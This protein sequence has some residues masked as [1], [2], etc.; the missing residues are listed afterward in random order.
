M[1]VTRRFFL[2]GALSLTATSALTA[3]YAFGL[4]PFRLRVQRYTLP[5]NGWSGRPLSIAALS[6][7]HACRPWMGPARIEAIVETT[8]ALA[9]D[10]IVLLGDYTAGHRFVTDWVN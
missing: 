7:I 6:D 2:N 4:E 9:S 5:L 10:L 8:H 3:G 1:R